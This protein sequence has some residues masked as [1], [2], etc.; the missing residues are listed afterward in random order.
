MSKLLSLLPQDDIATLNDL[1]R[2][3][4]RISMEGEHLA[5]FAETLRG[6]V[7]TLVDT[8]KSFLSRFTSKD[9][10]LSTTEPPVELHFNEYRKFVDLLEG[11]KFTS[12]SDVRWFVPEGFDGKLIDYTQALELCAIHTEGII[13]AVLNPYLQF[14]SRIVTSKNATMNSTRELAFL[15]KRDED[16][17]RLQADVGRFFKHGSTESKSTIGD[18][19]SRNAD[20]KPFFN[21]L[22][23]LR[24]AVKAV[25]PEQV[26]NSV[27]DVMTMLDALKNA[28]HNGELDSSSAST[29][30][31]LSEGTLSAAKEVEFYSVTTFRI[32]TL[33]NIT[34]SNMKAVPEL[35]K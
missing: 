31:N 24:D 26:Q 3:D 4:A 10:P 23:Q 28:V 19:I 21:G 9:S 12:L 13:G 8:T 5:N 32:F 2:I 33:G 1:R 11:H 15:A 17:E 25:K 14:L 7:P 27:K 29:L 34:Q 16:R 20:W 6:V 22:G 30:K 35:L 18:V